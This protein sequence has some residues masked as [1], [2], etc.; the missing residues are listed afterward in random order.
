MLGSEVEELSQQVGVA[1]DAHVQFGETPELVGQAVLLTVVADVLSHSGGYG[2]T[3]G[4]D[5]ASGTQMGLFLRQVQVFVYLVLQPPG[6]D[7]TV[8]LALKVP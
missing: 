4:E 3:D 5:H 2:T 6:V 7:R 1:L 8:S